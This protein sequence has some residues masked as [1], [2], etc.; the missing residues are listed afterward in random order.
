MDVATPPKEV[1]NKEVGQVLQR[2]ALLQTVQD[3]MD[4]VVRAAFAVKTTIA[5]Q[6]SGTT[7]A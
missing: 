3:V 6:L 1:V 4:A 2:A 7:S 5:A